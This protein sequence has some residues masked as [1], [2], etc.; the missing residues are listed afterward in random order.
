[1][2]IKNKDMEYEYMGRYCFDIDGTI[3]S[4]EKPENYSKAIP[5]K[6][7]IQKINEL[8]DEGHIIYLYTSRHMDK[9]RTTKEWMKKFNVKYHHIFFGKPVAQIYIDD[10]AVKP[11]EFLEK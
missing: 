4:K 8:F 11:E 1:M 2:D 6:L 10:L 5:N 3:C 7:M 9:E